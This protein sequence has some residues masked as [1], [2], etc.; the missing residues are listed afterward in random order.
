MA[1]DGHARTDGLSGGSAAGITTFDY[2]LVPFSNSDSVFPFRTYAWTRDYGCTSHT[3][4][5]LGNRV[6]PERYMT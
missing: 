5:P 6:E 2:N 1:Q 3:V 4:L